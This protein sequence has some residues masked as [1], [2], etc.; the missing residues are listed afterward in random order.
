MNIFFFLVFKMEWWDES[1]NWFVHNDFIVYACES[2][3][4]LCFWFMQVVAERYKF[5][6]L[7]QHQVDKLPIRSIYIQKKEESKNT[8]FYVY[9]NKTK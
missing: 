3:F 8:Q 4:E 7:Q 9:G 1:N 2:N 6:R 5:I